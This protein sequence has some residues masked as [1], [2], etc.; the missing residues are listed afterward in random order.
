[1]TSGEAAL[2]LQMREARGGWLAIPA[3]IGKIARQKPLATI[4]FVILA[5]VW[6]FCLLAPVIAPYGWDTLF[7]A[8]KLTGPSAAHWLGTDELGRDEYSRL[9]F[10][11]RLSLSIGVAA[12]VIGIAIAVLSGV[13]SG[14]ILGW[15][16]LVFQRITD[17]LQALPGLVVL[18]VIAAVF[19][20][21][22]VI[23][24]CAVAALYAPA[25]GRLYRSQTLAVRNEP[26]VEAAKV[27]GASHR[28]IIIR[29]IMPNVVPLIIVS[30]TVAVGAN[31]LILATLS[32]LGVFPG[33]YPDWGKMLNYSA[34]SFMVVAPWLAVAPGLAITVTVL[35]Y[36][37]LGD[38]L[39]DILDP[40]L[41]HG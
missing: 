22:R 4:A 14:Y 1:M 32:F 29:H 8:P 34:A 11:G 25:A 2:D 21:D 23:V 36:N 26:Y 5:I 9:L 38:G 19:K 17:A 20:G 15:F 18:L 35:A 16:D 24:L 7:V 37:L 28:R 12:T 30:A 13:I 31:L 40:R 33:D 39:R 27:V 6:A 10:A 3:Q 41:R